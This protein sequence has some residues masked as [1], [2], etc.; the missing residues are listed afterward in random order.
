MRKLDTTAKFYAI[1]AL[2][3]WAIILTH[4]LGK[5]Y[6][7][8]EPLT[9]DW[10]IAN[11]LDSLIRPAPGLLEIMTGYCIFQLRKPLK[12]EWK[13]VLSFY[14]KRAIEW[15]LPILA[16]ICLILPYWGTYN[17]GNVSYT[18]IFLTFSGVLETPAYPFWLGLVIIACDLVAPAMWLLDTTERRVSIHLLTLS[19]LFLIIAPSI[20]GMDPIT[21]NLFFKH[22]GYLLIGGYYFS[23]VYRRVMRRPNKNWISGI[24]FVSMIITLLI[25]FYEHWSGIDRWY[26]HSLRD[27][28]R[29]YVF[30]YTITSAIFIFMFFEAHKNCVTTLLK[31]LH[32]CFPAF[33]IHSWII[34]CGIY[35]SFNVAVLGLVLKTVI[36]AGI[37]W[38]WAALWR[39]IQKDLKNSRAMIGKEPKNA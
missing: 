31:L 25:P 29:V 38:S 18:D 28:T 16:M 19:W 12:W 39:F 5:Y 8:S 6:V 15:W 7:R 17:K 13:A 32:L 20:L 27:Y 4:I 23:P 3:Y 35:W 24:F 2:S 30:L 14:E 37:I 36:V 21:N 22:V 33:L 1:A 26:P 11:L 34:E 9:W 10:G